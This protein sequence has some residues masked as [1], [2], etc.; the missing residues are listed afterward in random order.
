MTDAD[1]TWTQTDCPGSSERA[2]RERFVTRAKAAGASTAIV[3]DMSAS[4]MKLPKE[5]GMP[6]PRRCQPRACKCD[7]A[8][9]TGKREKF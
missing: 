7:M 5:C 8:T 6:P 1:F 9:L 2:A 4:R 3:V